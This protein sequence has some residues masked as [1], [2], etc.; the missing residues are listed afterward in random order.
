[1]GKER[2]RQWP[3]SKMFDPKVISRTTGLGS[4]KC[5]R[6][7]QRCAVKSILRLDPHARPSVLNGLNRAKRLNPSIHNSGQD[8]LNGLSLQDRDWSGRVG[9]LARTHNLKQLERFEL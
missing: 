5:D 8:T 4:C 3:L 9:T 1:M 6:V 7:K 2:K